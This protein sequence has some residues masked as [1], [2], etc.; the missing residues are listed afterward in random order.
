M[1]CERM[2]RIDIRRLPWPLPD[3][4]QIGHITVHTTTTPCHLGGHR[5]WF[6]CPA[7]DRRC[8][9]L[10]PYACRLCVKGRY[11]CEAESPQDRRIMRALKVRAQLGQTERGLMAPF[12]SKPKRMRWH[13]WLRLRRAALEREAALWAE[14]VATLDREQPGWRQRQM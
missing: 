4:V 6:L 13:T 8:A 10:Y 5:Y 14:D 7:C 12:P 2:N 3:H 11:A 1:I 9:I